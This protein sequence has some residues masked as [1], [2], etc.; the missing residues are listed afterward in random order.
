MLGGTKPRVLSRHQD[1]K[2]KILN[3]SFSRVVVEPT[4]CHNM[5]VPLRHDWPQNNKYIMSVIVA[6]IV[7][8]T[9]AYGQGVASSN[10]KRIMITASYIQAS[11]RPSRR[12]RAS[13]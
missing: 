4:T 9:R 12:R 1:E 11:F 10:S 8:G 6:C 7:S 13:N 2:I 5:L 3:I